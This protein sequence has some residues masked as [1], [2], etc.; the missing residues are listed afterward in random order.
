MSEIE[1]LKRQLAEKDLFIKNILK[2]MK[3]IYE[4]VDG[5]KREADLV[6]T[7]FLE[8]MKAVK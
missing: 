7:E 3:E 6:G 8:M 1:S 2:E 5:L 4:L